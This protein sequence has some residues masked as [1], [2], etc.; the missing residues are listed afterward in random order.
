MKR[1]LS[2]QSPGL[3]WQR[4]TTLLLMGVL[5]WQLMWIAAAYYFTGGVEFGDDLPAYRA[6]V[7]DPLMLFT[8]RHRLHFGGAVAPPL[9]PV[10]LKA[11]HVLFAP[12]GDFL[13]FRLTMLLHVLPAL[14]VGF[15]VAFARNA[16]PGSWRQ[17]LFA[18]AIAVVPVAWVMVLTGQDDSIAAA[19]AAVCLAAWVTLGPIACAIAAGMGMFFGKIFIVLAFLALWVATPGRRTQIAAIGFAF[20]AGLFAL[21]VWRDRGLSYAQYVYGPYM[22]ASVYGIVWLLAGEFNLIT[23]RNI[24]AVLTILACLSFVAITLRRR[25]SFPSAVT[26]LHLIFLM[27]YFGAMPDYY[28]WFLPFLVVTLWAC[29]RDR[30]WTTFAAGWLSTFLAYGYKVLYGLNP[31]FP[32]KPGLKAWSVENIPFDIGPIQIACAIA[33]VICT[34][35]FALNVLF[36]D[37][38]NR[39]QAS[40]SGDNAES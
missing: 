14:F 16:P 33:A 34:V 8:D 6:Y 11:F 22:G 40:S 37:P 24:S 29:Y 13:A 31:Q 12:L 1:A 30:L 27:T 21:L 10:E 3:S 20:V 26:S 5:V 32:G 2:P 23:A 18:V 19:W 38:G 25:V 9:L 7:D 36:L 39:G 15:A 4:P 17:W 28:G 35:L